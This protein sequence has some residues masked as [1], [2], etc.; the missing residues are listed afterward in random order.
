MVRG[1]DPEAVEMGDVVGIDVGERET[2]G[3]RI[4]VFQPR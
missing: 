2:T 1:V 3:D 4:V